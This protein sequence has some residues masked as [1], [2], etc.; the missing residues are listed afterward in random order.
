MKNRLRILITGCGAPG[1]AGTIYS[2]RNN[3]DE[4]DI[5][6]I[7]TDTKD[8]VVGKYLCDRF[9]AI[10][11][12]NQKAEYTN[13]LFSVCKNEKI[14][15][16]IPQN[17]SEL[18]TLSGQKELFASIGT[19]LLISATS[20]LEKAN[21]KFRLM[22]ICRECGVPAGDFYLV[23]SFENLLK[24]ACE[25]GWPDKKV[26]IKPPVSNGLRGVR[27]IDESMDMKKL[28][29]EEKPT[30]MFIKMENLKII[31]GTDF[32]SL[33]I[34]EYLPGDEF[35][36]DILKTNGR[37]AVVPR[38]RDIIRSGITF[39][40]SIEKN[41]EIINYSKILARKLDLNYCF[42]FQFKIDP[43]G[44]PKILEANPRVQ[45][46]MVMSTI[47]GANLIYSAVKNLLGEDYPEFNIDW[48]SKFYRYWGGIGIVRNNT[49][50]I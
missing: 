25:L 41:N 44:V 1:I 18:I 17:T 26:V 21:D 13:G 10:P 36:V 46:T 4:R 42:G 40:G 23:D 33:I 12:A 49:I 27:I 16:V 50:Q 14:D 5:F 32:P 35:S 37:I 15:I 47:S 24:C 9:Y 2:L 38:K 39:A 6:I 45:G 8:E 22:Q 29:Y 34:T 28:F 19:S 3:H 43:E 7:G 11:A 30:S 48:N 31:L 20:A